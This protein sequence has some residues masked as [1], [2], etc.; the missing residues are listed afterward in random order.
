[1]DTIEHVQGQNITVLTKWIRWIASHL[2]FSVPLYVAT[3][4]AW[5]YL[6]TCRRVD[7]RDVRLLPVQL[8]SAFLL[9]GFCGALNSHVKD[10]SAASKAGW[11]LAIGALLLVCN[12]LLF[13]WLMTACAS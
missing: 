10:K 12:K 8:T 4:L 5:N 7:P 1:M 6:L 9:V 13:P 3:N 2:G 11:F